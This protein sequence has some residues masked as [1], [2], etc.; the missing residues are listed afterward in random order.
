MYFRWLG[1]EVPALH[2]QTSPSL[3]WYVVHPLLVV[4]A[5]VRSEALQIVPCPFVLTLC[6]R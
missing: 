2:T 5:T 1:S 6:L 3:P 4:D